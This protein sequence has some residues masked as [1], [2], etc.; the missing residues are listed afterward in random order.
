MEA[1]W[2]HF[3]IQTHGF[4]TETV[5]E[6]PLFGRAVWIEVSGACG[7]AL[8]Y[9]TTNGRIRFM[10]LQTIIFETFTTILQNSRM[11]D[12]CVTY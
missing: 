12:V 5:V 10:D 9:H 6:Q 4:D 11:L 8:V 3:E 1:L 2:P 7:E